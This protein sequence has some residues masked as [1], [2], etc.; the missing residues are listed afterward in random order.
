MP[1][2]VSF[3]R[4]PHFSETTVQSGHQNNMI[5]SQTDCSMFL[6]QWY[7]YYP[8]PAQ[9]HRQPVERKCYLKVSLT[10]RGDSKPSA[11]QGQVSFQS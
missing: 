6:I 5:T 11:S 10:L 7:F 1:N 4:N 2:H 3:W 9:K 8:S